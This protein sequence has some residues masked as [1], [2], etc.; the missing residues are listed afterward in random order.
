M[1]NRSMFDGIDVFFLQVIITSLC[2]KLLMMSALL[3]LTI[4]V[5]NQKI[6]QNR[7]EQ[8]FRRKS[9]LEKILK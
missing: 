1:T 3:Q 8:L 4:A 9:I 6:S 7:I 5:S 2:F